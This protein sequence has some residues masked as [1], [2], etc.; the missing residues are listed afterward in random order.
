MDFWHEVSTGFYWLQRRVVYG[1]GSRGAGWAQHPFSSV[2]IR[3]RRLTHCFLHY[4]QYAFSFKSNLQMVSGLSKR[5]LFASSQPFRCD[6][7][8]SNQGSGYVNPNYTDNVIQVVVA[9]YGIKRRRWITCPA[10]WSTRT[11]GRNLPLKECISRKHKLR[12][13]RW[14]C[15]LKPENVSG[16]RENCIMRSFIIWITE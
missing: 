14:I 3:T 11:S 9:A 10:E 6:R 7:W 4:P 8:N 5:K 2:Y 16:V 12:V 13:L 15:G 1:K